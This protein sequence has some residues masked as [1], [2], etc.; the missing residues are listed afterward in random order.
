MTKNNIII[1]CVPFSFTIIT[2]F[3][4]FNFLKLL[5]VYIL[6]IQS[7]LEWGTLEEKC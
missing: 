7:L 6:T 4:Y 1:V 3:L 2:C 5:S